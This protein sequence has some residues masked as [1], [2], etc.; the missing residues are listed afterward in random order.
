MIPVFLSEMVRVVV[1]MTI[2]GGV[3][4][5]LLWGLGPALW[6]RLPK[7]AQYACWLV[8][9][10]AFLLPLSMVR[11]P[12]PGAAPIHGLVE[13]TVIS[14]LEH[15]HRT[16][17]AA[18]PSYAAPGEELRL[19]MN[20]AEG[21]HLPEATAVVQPVTTYVAVPAH[22]VIPPPSV[23]TVVSTAFMRVYL[24]GAAL[25]LLFGAAGYAWFLRKLRRGRVDAA[26]NERAVL[27][28]LGAG[29][30]R[31][32]KSSYAAT[33]MLVGVLRP[34]I[35]LPNRLYSD[36][37]LTAIF[38]H[39]LT[40]KRRGDVWVKWLTL[41]ACALH[42]FN[43][44]VWLARREINR[45]CELACDEAVIRRMDAQRKQQYGNT[46][47]AVAANK[48]APALSATMSTEKQAIQ[49]RLTAIMRSQNPTR[50][51]LLAS[52][53]VVLAV[54]GIVLALGAGRNGD[55]ADA[56]ALADA[57]PPPAYEPAPTPPP[58]DIHIIYIEDT[59]LREELAAILWD[60]IARYG[61]S[62]RTRHDGIIDAWQVDFNN[63][64]RPMLL[65][66]LSAMDGHWV[67]Y[68]IYTMDGMR[69]F[70][71]DGAPM[72]PTPT[73]FA[74]A[75]TD[76]GFI[77]L[78]QTDWHVH[79]S[80]ER[81]YSFASGYAQV[82]FHRNIFFE[83]FDPEAGVTWHS[84]NNHVVAGEYGFNRILRT[85]GIIDIARPIDRLTRI[86]LRQVAAAS[87]PA[88]FHQPLAIGLFESSP[89][90]FMEFFN[91]FD[92]SWGYVFTEQNG[93]PRVTDIRA[94]PHIEQPFMAFWTSEFLPDFRL[95]ILGTRE[96]NGT[97]HLYTR[98]ELNNFPWLQPYMVL[99][100]NAQFSQAYH[101]R[102]GVTFTDRYNISH[103]L[104]VY[105][106]QLY[107]HNDQDFLPWFN[108][109]PRPFVMGEAGRYSVRGMG[110]HYFSFDAAQNS[111]T[112]AGNQFSIH[113][114][115]G[116][117][118]VG[119][120]QLQD[121]TLHVQVMI[122]RN[123]Q[124]RPYVSGPMGTLFGPQI[125]FSYNLH[126]VSGLAQIPVTFDDETRP[127]LYF[128]L[129]VQGAAELARLLLHAYELI[130]QYRSV[131]M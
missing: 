71:G 106:N 39:E 111:F 125:T 12:A 46:L 108:F 85:R 3:L 89:A 115:V 61:V 70:D 77:Y 31:L 32:Y 119:N 9:L 26:P 37:Q 109:P 17:G 90:E 24:P 65:F 19:T 45:S 59:P 57:A 53:L 113:D 130:Q 8:V 27:T 96:I 66:T 82:S 80:E 14:Q 23:A 91:G 15:E 60:A 36:E 86:N 43:P 25:V 47:I 117:S 49:E 69:I 28:Q 6:H 63:D 84:V 92:G 120:A 52:T 56:D 110:G 34:A 50:L 87:P 81:F 114:L 4:G 33:P 127:P 75:F 95:F 62:P 83:N 11:L 2:T 123:E 68:I 102:I 42:W 93:A 1:L 97:V 116:E 5:L 51:A 129:S 30:T 58:A 88:A 104:V 121:N 21:G 94:R 72:S 48:P 101:P 98:Y 55:E 131:F 64:G 41:A 74:L 99:L 124:V 22:E 103:R 100:L 29:K 54:I 38:L 44:V 7:G 73:H 76:D 107:I 126:G 40:H 35:I 122:G 13:R 18:L 16:G 20:P 118:I 67:R 112:F 105:N 79:G 78:Q 128:D 10:G